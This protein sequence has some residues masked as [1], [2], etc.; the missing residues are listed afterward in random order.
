MWIPEGDTTWTITF[1]P[2]GGDGEAFSI[3]AEQNTVNDQR[4][5]S[6]TTPYAKEHGFVRD[7]YIFV[8]WS[9]TS[10]GA[11]DASSVEVDNP[12]TYI[13]NVQ[14]STTKYHTYYAI[15][16]P[17]NGEPGVTAYYFVRTD[18]N[19]PFEPSSYLT[20][21]YFPEHS[22]E[23]SQDHY[24][25][26]KGTIKYAIA[27]NNNLAK[28]KANLG[29][30]PSNEKIQEEAE[31]FGHTFDPDTQYIEW[32]VIK[33]QEDW[34][35]D[36]VIRDKNKY[37]VTYY[38]NGGNENVPPQ[39]EHAE[40]EIVK[41]RFDRIPQRAGYNFLGWDENKDAITPTYPHTVYQSG[42]EQQF[43]MP[44]H[45]VDL[46]AIWEPV[47]FTLQGYKVWNDNNNSGGYRPDSV[48]L[49]LTKKVGNNPEE[50][51]NVEPV[52]TKGTGNRWTW[53]YENL[54]E[55][56]NDELI[57]YDVKEIR[58]DSD[59]EVSYSKDAS[60]I[61]VITNS[62]KTGEFYIQKLFEGKTDPDS[63]MY[64]AV[65]FRL[66]YADQDWNK[67]N[68]ALETVTVDENGIAQFS[69]L[70]AG[71]YWIAELET[72]SGYVICQDIKLEVIA[73]DGTFTYK[74]NEQDINF[75]SDGKFI[76]QLTNY[77]GV[78]LPETG[79]PGIIMMER[80]GWM[81]LLLALVGA[82]VQLF[83]R[84]RRKEQ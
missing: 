37:K 53:R 35:V 66:Y 54:P 31:Y 10:S 64:E 22:V 40:G 6:F 83:N 33:K 5:Y 1:D 49:Q 42:S 19:V 58:V 51:V 25:S 17:E 65:S 36:G 11:G 73:E 62:L 67:G 71:K 74:V 69:G 72:A 8:G 61:P 14:V 26:L 18:G 79:G 43:T 48:Q 77:R 44:G 46:Y 28:V 20:G 84:R 30:I 3:E 2:N 29:E 15:W 52:W 68:V 32:Y 7:G 47:R 50:V 9:A 39:T 70:S 4:V 34:H 56:E 63:S 27:I 45:D 41:V 38:P 13:E 82:D 55:Y 81:L 76:Y 24:Y 12:G 59:Y 78:E 57:K 16:L 80:F 21:Y 60:G 75:S 23:G